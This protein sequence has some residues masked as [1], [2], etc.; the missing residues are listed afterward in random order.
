MESTRA[1]ADLPAVTT[2]AGDSSDR[3]SAIARRIE[4]LGIT[5]R[6]WHAV[7]GIDRKTLNRAIRNEPGTRPGTYTAIEAELDKLEARNAGEAV[8]AAQQE[9]APGV[10]RVE[11][12][13]VYGAKAL[14]FQAPVENIDVLEQMVDRIMRRLAAGQEDDQQ[15]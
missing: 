4:A 15:G 1:R 11:V 3:G 10:V 14:V 8:T 7:T 9:I 12:Q 13:G 2:S 6:E 5:D